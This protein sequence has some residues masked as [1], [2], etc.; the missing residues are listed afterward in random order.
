MALFIVKLAKTLIQLI[1]DGVICDSRYSGK[2]GNCRCS[3]Q[4]ECKCVTYSYVCVAIGVAHGLLSIAFRGY[5]LVAE[6]AGDAQTLK[7][8]AR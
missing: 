8:R 2:R 7:G 4:A 3:M 1:V 5:L 6:L